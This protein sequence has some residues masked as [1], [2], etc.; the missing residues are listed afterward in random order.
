MRF[1]GD[2][3]RGHSDAIT[4][5][6]NARRYIRAMKAVD[7][8]IQIVA[9]GHNDM[10]WNRAVLQAVGREIDILSIH[11]YQ[12]ASEEAGDRFNLMARPLWYESFYDR[13]HK[14]IQ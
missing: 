8:A 14:L 3:V 10:G 11:H 1:W 6:A 12:G 4:H 7:P 9:V 13:F 5:A 2:W